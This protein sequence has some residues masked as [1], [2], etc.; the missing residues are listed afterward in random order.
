M[1]QKKRR[2]D[3]EGW[4]W[5]FE[6]ELEKVRR[7]II[8]A[9]NQYKIKVRID[10]VARDLKVTKK[11][12]TDIEEKAEEFYLRLARFYYHEHGGIG[13]A[14]KR[15]DDEWLL[16]YLEFFD[17]ITGYR[18]NPELDRK[19]YRAYEE[20]VSQ[21][22]IHVSPARRIDR[23]MDLLNKQITQKAIDIVLIA[24]IDAYRSQGIKQVRW[25]T[26]QDERVCGECEPRH[27]KIYDIDKLPERHYY[28]R[29]WLEPVRTNDKVKS[30]NT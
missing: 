28:C 19:I 13:P 21:I 2:D 1:A 9:F 18:Y 12:Y 10:V 15:Y 29:C 17:P 16:E 8:K 4:W 23:C 26:M 20:V 11:L 22:D 5:Y 3:D 14:R 25:Y 30:G 24:I 27:G 7:Y 6:E